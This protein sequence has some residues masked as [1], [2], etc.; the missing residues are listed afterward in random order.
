MLDELVGVFTGQNR[1]DKN[2]A[3]C[4]GAVLGFLGGA[5]VGGILGILFAP[6]PGAETRE[7]IGNAAVK[8]YE[9]VKEKA[10][11]VG[12][13]VT[14]KVSETYNQF[15]DTMSDEQRE[16]RRVA[17][18]ARRAARNVAEAVADA[19]DDVI[20]EVEDVVDEVT[21]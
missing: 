3:V 9:T 21:N 1:R 12:S 18:Q 7:D 13:K 11:D 19:T 8:G 17:R 20:E 14:T 10:T 5:A 4:T 16:A 6:K 15:K 2:R